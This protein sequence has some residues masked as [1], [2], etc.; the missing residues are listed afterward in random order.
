MSVIH[1]PRRPE[2]GVRQLVLLGF[3]FIALFVVFLRLWFLQVVRSAELSERTISFGF[4]SFP[5]PSPRG[6][7]VDR[8]GSLL[9]GVHSELVVTVVPAQIKKNKEVLPK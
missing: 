9:A 4:D 7:I 6:L 5:I 8:R 1:V 3:L 2:I